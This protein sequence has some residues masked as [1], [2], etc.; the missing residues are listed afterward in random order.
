M[1]SLTILGG[2]TTRDVLDCAPNNFELSEYFAR[3][4]IVS[5]MSPAAEIDHSLIDLASSFQKRCVT[6]DISKTFF[7]ELEKKKGQFI[8]IDFISE[9]LNLVKLGDAY[10]TRSNELVKS[11]VLDQLENYQII[12][13]LDDEIQQLWK[14]H[15]LQFFQKLKKYFGN[16]I[17]L[18]KTKWRHFYLDVDGAVKEFPNVGEIK[19]RNEELADYYAFVEE[20]FPEF[21]FI[22]MTDDGYYASADHKWGLAP[23]HFED[24]YYHSLLQKLSH[25]TDTWISS[26]YEKIINRRI[27]QL[28]FHTRIESGENCVPTLNGGIF[29]GEHGTDIGSCDYFEEISLFKEMNQTLQYLFIQLNDAVQKHKIENFQEIDTKLS[30]LLDRMKD[31]NVKDIF[32]NSSYLIGLLITFLVRRD[33]LVGSRQYE[34][35]VQQLVKMLYTCKQPLADYELYTTLYYE[36]PLFDLPS[37]VMAVFALHDVWQYTKDTRYA[38]L[39]EEGK[40]QLI[41]VLPLYEVKGVTAENLHHVLNDGNLPEYSAAFHLLNAECLSL[42]YSIENDPALKDI[43]DRWLSFIRETA[44]YPEFQDTGFSLLAGAEDATEQASIQLGGSSVQFRI[45][46]NDGWMTSARISR[47]EKPEQIVLHTFEK[48]FSFPFGRAD[49]TLTIQLRDQFNNRFERSYELVN[50]ELEEARFIRLLKN[51]EDNTSVTFN[52]DK[53]NVQVNRPLQDASYAYYIIINDK[54]IHKEWY[55][56]NTNFQFPVTQ[57]EEI[58]TAK[59]VVFVKRGTLK[60]NYTLTVNV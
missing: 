35:M 57:G 36:E 18:H 10:I 27:V 5:M 12:K 4:S 17:I 20:H 9:R 31:E 37:N 29:T 15:A 30:E 8:V 58:E 42:L 22:D 47:K 48:A 39:Y 54:V 50:E 11:K 7:N 52:E 49:Y 2:C 55:S 59:C 53:L 24:R 34:E 38:A 6:R 16:N 26:S 41:K 46:C 13:K 1:T 25:V 32:R 19:L 14:K 56:G 3:T 33:L 23:Y 40:E 28:F 45:S 44:A 60:K 51:L 21:I 43:L